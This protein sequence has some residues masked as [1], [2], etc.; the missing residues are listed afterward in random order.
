MVVLL[1]VIDAHCLSHDRDAIRRK[2]LLRDTSV[3]DHASTGRDVEEFVECFLDQ[4][5]VAHVGD[6]AY[7]VRVRRDLGQIGWKRRVAEM[8]AYIL[9]NRDHHRGLGSLV[10]LRQAK[11]EIRY[12]SELFVFDLY[13]IKSVTQ[14]ASVERQNPNL[15]V[16]LDLNHDDRLMNGRR[17]RQ[18]Q[19]PTAVEHIVVVLRPGSVPCPSR[20]TRLVCIVGLIFLG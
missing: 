19:R 8:K 15:G 17:S 5:R 6:R 9:L 16:G 20:G 2:V 10:D 18:I 1:L 11:R 7:D 12:Q 13:G 14:P 4:D 3:D